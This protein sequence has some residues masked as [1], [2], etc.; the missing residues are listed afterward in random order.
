[1]VWSG[2]DDDNH[3]A[4]LLIKMKKGSILFAIYYPCIHIFFFFIFNLAAPVKN[5]FFFF[6]CEHQRPA[7]THTYTFFVLHC[8]MLIYG[9]LIVYVIVGLS[10][11]VRWLR[12]CAFICSFN[13]TF[14]CC[15]ATTQCAKI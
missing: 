13:Q 14:L 12:V 2:N 4:V 1:M 5:M 3:H 15:G 9:L 10:I 7:H 11:F 8:L 6:W